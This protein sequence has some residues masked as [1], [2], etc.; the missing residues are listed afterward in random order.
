[1]T[2]WLHKGAETMEAIWRKWGTEEL[3]YMCGQEEKTKTELNHY[4]VFAQFKTRKR[5]S[6]VV[7]IFPSGQWNVRAAKGTLEQNQA[8][9]SKEESRIGSHMEFG[10]AVV[11]GKR[12]DL[13]VVKE[14]I[15]DGVTIRELWD[16]HWD[17][18]VRH[19][20]GVKEG[21]RVLQAVEVNADYDMKEFGSWEPI[22]DWSTSHI[23]AGP[24]GIGKTQFALAHF[25]QP[26]LISHIDQLG[27]I[28]WANCDGL[29]FD[30]MH[31][32]GSNEG[33]GRW[34]TCSQIHLVDV[35][36]KR[37]INIK[38]GYAEIPA[39]TKKI[40]TTNVEGGMCVDLATDAISRRCTVH[41]LTLEDRKDL[42]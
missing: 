15:D 3:N 14:K 11:A 1:M 41:E 30:D 25:K 5:Q 4:Q 33:K 9:T 17:T 34:A 7:K 28:D 12:T 22:D 37:A 35:D 21:M 6:G 8:Y 13:T 16:A 18:M 26:M 31:F 27:I 23:F 38:Y 36:M 40:F 10:T 39:H 2:G 29:V 24:T 42:L 32:E 19:S 20:K